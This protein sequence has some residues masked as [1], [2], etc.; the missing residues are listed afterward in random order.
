[1]SDKKDTAAEQ[2]ETVKP[3]N[4]L[5]NNGIFMPENLSVL[6]DD[7]YNKLGR[8][9]TLKMD[10]IIMPIIVIMYIMN[11]LDRQNIASAKLADIDKDLNLSP[12]QYQ[13]AISILFCS[14]S[15]S[16]SDLHNAQAS[17]PN[18]EY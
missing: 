2:F 5:V 4:G 7:E 13:T 1:M 16:K 6:S 10:M 18:S 17:Y 12:V 15:K 3:D 11:Y 14:Y 8:R 9:A